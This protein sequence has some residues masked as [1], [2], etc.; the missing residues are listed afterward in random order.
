MTG[1][2]IAPTS[3]MQAGVSVLISIIGS[4]C[5]GFIFG[6][7]SFLIQK[8]NHDHTE[9]HE[10]LE[11]LQRNLIQN[12]VPDQLKTRVYDYFNAYWKKKR[13]FNRF[14]DFSE[15]SEPLQREL[16]FHIHQDL[17]KTVPLFRE[18]ESIEIFAII[19]KLQ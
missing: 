17:I 14:S 12:D 7:I 11:A 13:H 3:T 16:A 2:E 1:N 19:K 15:L 5:L 8:I 18:L 6:S 9:Y 10:K 4:M